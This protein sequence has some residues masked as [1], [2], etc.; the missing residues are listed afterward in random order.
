MSGYGHA[1]KIAAIAAGASA[2][3]G[4]KPTPPI[5]PR[6]YDRPEIRPSWP[7]ATSPVSYT[8]LTLPTIYSV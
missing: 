8:H 6:L 3:G 4:E 1:D 2:A 7:N 5:D